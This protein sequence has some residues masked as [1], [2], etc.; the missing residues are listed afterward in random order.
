MKVRSI[1]IMCIILTMSAR[2]VEAKTFAWLSN[3]KNTVSKLDVSQNKIVQTIKSDNLNVMSD[4]D[5]ERRYMVNPI[6]GTLCAVYN[7]AARGAGQGVKIISLSD[8][9]IKKDLYIRSLDPDEVFPVIIMPPASNKFYVVWWD[10]LKE[11]NGEG[12]ETISSFDSTTFKELQN[13]ITIP[14]DYALPSA[15]SINTN[16]LYTVDLDNNVIKHY[17]NSLNL[18]KTVPVAYLWNS[19]IFLKRIDYKSNYGKLLLME[20]IKASADMPNDIKYF[21]YDLET[22]TKSTKFSIKEKGEKI[23]ST[24]GLKLVVNEITGRENDA[25]YTETWPINIIHIYDTVTGIK[26][27]TIDLSA[28]YKGL[29]LGKISPDS[30]KLYVYAAKRSDNVKTN[31]TVLIIDLTNYAV[32]SELPTDDRIIEFYEQ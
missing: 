4:L 29:R 5:L 17:D 31:N 10:K 9:V 8:L 28:K 23:L 30:T 21:V 6:N 12:G 26:I 7:R 1:I 3:F 24:D 22:N 32:L 27:K 20:N 18:L 13:D 11:V 2:V 15:I 19:T 14:I 16:K 25:G